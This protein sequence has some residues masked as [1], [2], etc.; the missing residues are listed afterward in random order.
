MKSIRIH[1]HGGPEVIAIDDIPEPELLP[2][3]VKIKLAFTALNHMDLWVRGGLPGVSIPLPIILGCEGSGVIEAVGPGCETVK[4]GDHVMIQPGL[5]CG[6]CAHCLSGNDH[7]CRSYQIL[8]EHTDGCH[9]ESMVLPEQNVIVIPK[10]MSLQDAAALPLAYLTAWQMLVTRLALKPGETLLVV[11]AASGVGSAAVQIAKLLGVTV[12]ATAGDSEKCDRARALGADHV[13]EHKTQSISGEV[14]RITG[15]R[16]V[17]AVFE[18]VG[19]AVWTECLKSLAWQGRLVTCGATTGPKVDLDLRHVFIKNLQ[20]L[21][22]TMGRKADLHDMLPHFISGRLK[23]V[24]DRVY[25]FQEVKVAQARLEAS[26]NFGKIVL[27]F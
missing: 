2:H 11:A 17:D 25:P 13:I 3:T 16:G 26:Q 1:A 24:V 23:A 15:G 20:I 7:Y 18:H 21:G 9:R 5:S 10:T 19:R 14:K 6:V 12:I 22:S 8:G 27:S 4:F